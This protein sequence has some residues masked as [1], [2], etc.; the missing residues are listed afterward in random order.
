MK[1]EPSTGGMSYWSRA[2]C[3]A[4]TY[5]TIMETEKISTRQTRHYI[6]IPDSYKGCLTSAEAGKAMAEAL[7][8]ANSEAETI[9]MVA[10]DG[11]EGMLEAFTQA[12]GGTIFTAEVR[13]PMMRRVQASYGVAG[14]TAVIEVAQACG[15]TLLK[16]EERNPMRATSYGVGQLLHAARAHGCTYFIIGLGGSATS[17]AGIGMLK[18]LIEG[19]HGTENIDQVK[20]KRFADCHFVLA[21]DVQNPLCGPQG[22]AHIFAPQK[23]ATPAM[24]TELDRRAKQFADFSARHYSG[25]DCSAMPGAGAAGGLGYAFMQ[26]FEAECRSGADYL[27]DLYHFDAMLSPQTIVITGEGKSDEQTLMGKL[28][29]CIMRRAKAQGA[30]VWLV[31]GAIENGQTL[32]EA[33]FSRVSAVTPTSAPLTEAMLPQVAKANIKKAITS[34]LK[35]E[36]NTK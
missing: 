34:L 30:K 17:D 13:D 28:P 3:F 33:G 24:V 32:I 14:E 7:T 27:L 9:Q 8:T 25:R 35:E 19:T 29:V 6:I 31:S 12:M 26:Y 18:A 5:Q 23:G 1:H 16:E 11:G 4:Q 36:E 22:A 20:A 21:S 10:S 2:F 15:L